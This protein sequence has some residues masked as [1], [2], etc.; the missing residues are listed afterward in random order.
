MKYNSILLISTL[1]IS[2]QFLF[3]QEHRANHSFKI[4]GFTTIANQTNFASSKTVEYDPESPN[5]LYISFFNSANKI[6]TKTRFLFKRKKFELIHAA[7]YLVSEDLVLDG[8]H[9]SYLE[10]GSIDRELIYKSGS[11]KQEIEFYPNG[12]RK[13]LISSNDQSKNGAYQMWHLNGLLSFSG[14]YSNNLKNGEF[15]QFDESGKLIKKGIYLNGKLVS[16]APVVQDMIFKLPEIKAKFSKE[17]TGINEDLKLKFGAIDELKSSL[18]QKVKLNLII[19]KAGK[20]LEVRKGSLTDSLV[21]SVS[22]KLLKEM[23]IFLPA[24]VENIPVDSELIMEFQLSPEGLLIPSEEPIQSFIAVGK[25]RSENQENIYGT[26]EQMPEYPGGQDGLRNFLARTV[27]YPIEALQKGIQGK[28]FVNFVIDENGEVTKIQIAKGVHKSL[29]Q[30]A[31]RVVQL[32][33][34]WMPGIHDGKPVKVSYTVP[35]S[36]RQ[37]IVNSRSD[38]D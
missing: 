22:N 24:T 2:A 18:T 14:E 21:L 34:K 12:M 28:V 37:E 10:N 36:F 8:A 16:G 3:A 33:P 5:H 32:M 9:F 38:W 4:S 25:G 11:L 17:I 29:D 26:V 1:V 27:R 30:E 23:K 15:R 19:D 13:S 31:V 7:D 35:I 6:V 20:V